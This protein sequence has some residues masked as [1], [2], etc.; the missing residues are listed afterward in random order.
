MYVHIYT[1]MN[2]ASLDKVTAAAMTAKEKKHHAAAAF[3]RGVLNV[4]THIH[5]LNEY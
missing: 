1:Y 3:S 4:Y 5:M 2:M